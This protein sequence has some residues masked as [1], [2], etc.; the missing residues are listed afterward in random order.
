MRYLPFFFI[1]FL[2]EVILKPAQAQYASQMDAAY[3]A[4]LKAVADYKINDEE[5]LDEVE[6]LRQDEKFNKKLRKMLNKLDNRKSKNSENKRVY[7]ILKKAGR[8]IYNE[9][10]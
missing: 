3:L 6:E 2:E 4:T 8:D 9:L 10:K 5:N 7:E 1:F